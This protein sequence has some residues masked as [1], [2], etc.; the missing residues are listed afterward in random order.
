MCWLLIGSWNT[1]RFRMQPG[2]LTVYTNSWGTPKQS[3][4]LIRR[5]SQFNKV[6]LKPTEAYTLHSLYLFLLRMPGRCAITFDNTIIKVIPTPRCTSGCCCNKT[7]VVWK[8]SSMPWWGGCSCRKMWCYFKQCIRCISIY[9]CSWCNILYISYFSCLHFQLDWFH[10]CLLC[11]KHR[12]RPIRSLV[13]IWT[14]SYKMG[15]HLQGNLI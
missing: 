14:F 4:D 12:R 10:F 15:V 5:V 7:C 2:K 8:Y 6:Y 1:T 13:R 11:D 9:T 3:L